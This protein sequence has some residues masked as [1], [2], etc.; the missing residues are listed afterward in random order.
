MLI[1][2]SHIQDLPSIMEAYAR[3]RRFMHETGNPNQWINGYP[4][5]EQAIK[6]IQQGDNYVCLNED[7][8]F[9]GTFFFRVGDDPTYATIYNGQWLDD[10]P[11]G[12]VH[13]M[14]SNGNT[15]G[16]ADF[17]LQWC[18]RQ[19]PNIRVDTHPDNRVMRHILEKNGYQ[20]CGIIYVANGTERLAFQKKIVT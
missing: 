9:A 1:R 4:P 10:H 14:A 2:K 13:R 5:E 16:V 18:F 15:K 3:A 17:C 8:T 6:E 11:Y 12:V 7:E 19:H 20:Y